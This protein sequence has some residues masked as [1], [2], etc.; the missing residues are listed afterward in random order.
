MHVFHGIKGGYI[1]REGCTKK[2]EQENKN[3]KQK[4]KKYYFLSDLT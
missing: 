2:M 1:V 4:K 3:L